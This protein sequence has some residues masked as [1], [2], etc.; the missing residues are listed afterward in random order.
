M[1]EVRRELADHYGEKG[2]T[3]GGLSVR[4]T[5]D[6]GLQKIAQATLRQ[7][8][9]DYDRRH[10]YRG[11]VGRIEL[12]DNWQAKLDTFPLPEGVTDWQLAVVTVLEKRQAQIGFANGTVGQIPITELKWARK[13][14]EDQKVGASIKTPGDVIQPGDVVSGSARD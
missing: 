4:T 12:D 14:L 1:E 11:P 9:E 10:G 7:G 2:V 3:E 5:L 8:L 6:P 13:A